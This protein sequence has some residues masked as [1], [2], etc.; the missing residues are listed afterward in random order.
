MSKYHHLSPEER[1]FI[2]I[3]GDRGSSLRQIALEMGRSPATL[4]RELRLLFW[5]GDLKT[6]LSRVIKAVFGAGSKITNPVHYFES[7]F[8]AL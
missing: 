3:E 2:M 4:S 1:A 8:A 7:I 5:P 6:V